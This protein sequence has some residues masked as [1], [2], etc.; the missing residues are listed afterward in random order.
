MLIHYT[1]LLKHP[2]V[3]TVRE[4]TLGYT[5]LCYNVITAALVMLE[6]DT[7]PASQTLH[8]SLAGSYSPMSENCIYCISSFSMLRKICL[9]ETEAHL[10]MQLNIH[11]CLKIP[12]S[13]KP[14]L[15]SKKA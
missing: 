11:Q 13:E 2:L 6:L 1:F 3:A 10:V 4:L 5:E 9:S 15:A 7:D 12:F 14:T 8:I